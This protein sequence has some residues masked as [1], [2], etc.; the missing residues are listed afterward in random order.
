[1]VKTYT[2]IIKE[3]TYGYRVDGGYEPCLIL[4]CENGYSVS[5]G[6]SNFHSF[7][8][9]MIGKRIKLTIEE[10]EPIEDSE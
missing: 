3:H 7:F 1:M 4:Q 2:G 8:N 6:N 5:L 9:A 10:L